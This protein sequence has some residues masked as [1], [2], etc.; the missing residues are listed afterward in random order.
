MHNNIL[1]YSM[2]CIPHRTNMDETA[3]SEVDHLS[4][5]KCLRS[6]TV[7]HS[8]HIHRQIIRIQINSIFYLVLILLFTQRF[9]FRLGYFLDKGSILLLH[10]V[11]C[12]IC[13]IRA[14]AHNE[15]SGLSHNTFHCCASGHDIT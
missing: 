14:R 1:Q 5:Q 13:T 2:F 15:Y 11:P 4:E 12:C 7:Q 8:L 10:F 6:Q 3:C 9:S